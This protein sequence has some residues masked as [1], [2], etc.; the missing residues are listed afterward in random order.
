[1][2]VWDQA[3]MELLTPGLHSPNLKELNF[4]EKLILKNNQQMMKNFVKNYP[5]C[6]DSFGTFLSTLEHGGSRAGT[7]GQEPPLWK[8]T[9]YMG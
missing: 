7:R 9:S 1:M 5:A 8:I 6:K 3:G 4:S 2:K